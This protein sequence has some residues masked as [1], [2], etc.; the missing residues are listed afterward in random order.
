MRPALRASCDDAVDSM[1]PSTTHTES[2]RMIRVRSPKS[3]NTIGVIA[4]RPPGVA[5]TQVSARLA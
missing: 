5:R 3:S 4:Y 2:A 1:S